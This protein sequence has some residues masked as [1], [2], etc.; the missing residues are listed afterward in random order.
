MADRDR[1]ARA[2][3]PGGPHVLVSRSSSARERRT[4]ESVG[5]S[6]PAEQMLD[7][8]FCLGR[9]ARDR[10][11]DGPGVVGHR[12][13]LMAVEAYLHHASYALVAPFA[14]GLVAQMDLDAADLVREPIQRVFEHRRHVR[15]ESLDAV[16][17]VIRVDLNLHAKNPCTR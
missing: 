2:V 12:D 1:A 11:M 7:R 3:T 17:V 13:R 5:G 6:D 15:A 9:R 14:A 16:D 10:L 4:D 8:V